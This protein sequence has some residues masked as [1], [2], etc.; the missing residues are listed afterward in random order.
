MS[1]SPSVPSPSGVHVSA[2]AWKRWLGRGLRVLLYAVLALWSVLLLAWLTLHW[3]ILPRIGDWRP[4]IEQAASRALGL[5]VRIGALQVVS[6]SWVPVLELRE[7]ELQDERGQRALRLPRVVAAVSPGSLL[8]WQLRLSQ[9]HLDGPEAVVRRDAQGRWHVAGQGLDDAPSLQGEAAADWLFEQPEVVIQRG[10]LLL[11]DEQRGTPPLALEQLSAVLRNGLREHQWRIDAL[12]PAHWGEQISLRGRFQQP[13]LARAGDWKR[14]SGTL[15]A[16]GPRIEG[17][18]VLA[19]LRVPLALQGGSGHWR[20][21]LEARQGQWQHTTLDVALGATSFPLQSARA[22][23][24]LARLETRLQLDRRDDGWR[25]AV[26]GLRFDTADG[27]HWPRSRLAVHWRPQVGQPEL[28]SLDLDTPGAGEIEG[29]RLDLGALATLAE[30]LPLA[31]AWRQ[32]LAELEPRGQVLGLQARWS[33]PLQQP[34]HYRVK[35]RLQDLAIASRASPEAGGVGRPGWRGVGLELDADERGGQAQ[36]SLRQ[37]ALLLPGVFEDPVLA[38]DEFDARLVWS[39]QPRRQGGPPQI[40]LRVQDGRFANA[41]ARGDLQ[42]RWRTGDGAAGAPGRGQRYPGTLELSGQ[43]MQARA[44]AVARY[45]PLGVAASARRYVE[46]AVREGVVPRASFRVRGD[47]WDFPFA[48][49]S[50]GD[51]HVAAQVERAVLDYAPAA[52]VGPGPGWPAFTDVAGELVFDRGSMAIR[53]AKARLWGVALHDVNGR[54][55]DLIEHPRLRI[56]G[57]GRGPLTDALRFVDASPVAG[58]TRGALGQAVGSGAADLKL[59]L[60]IPLDDASRATVQGSVV[61][62]GNDVRLRRDLPLLRQARARIEFSDSGFSVSGGQAQ[63]LGGEARF[64]ASSQPDGRVQVKVQG[65]ASAEGLRQASELGALARLGQLA[66]GST[67]YQLQLGF[68]GERTEALFTSPLSGLA[69]ELPA[70]LRKSA[71][72]S[73]PLRVQLS[74]L[75][76]RG[77]PPRETLRVDLGPVL[78]AEYQREGVGDSPRVLRGSL[79]IGEAAPALPAAGVLASLKLG[80]V[81]LDEWWAWARG[82]GSDAGVGGSAAALLPTE[83]RA[84]AQ[85]LHNAALPLSQVQLSGSR[86]PADGLWQARLQ[87]DQAQGQLEWRAGTAALPGGQI[88][89]RLT[90]LSVPDSPVAEARPGPTPEPARSA[91]GLPALDVVV[92]ELDWKGKRLGR[93][94][95][96]S[97]ATAADARE[98]PINRLLIQRP[99]ARLQAQGRWSA[100]PQPGTR[101]DL[102]LQ[103][104]DSGALLE[105]WGLGRVLKGGK[106]EISG[107]LGWPGGPMEPPGALLSGELKL[108]LGEGQILKVEPGAGRLLGILSLQSLPRR[109][110]L[111]FRDIFQEGFSF[112]DISG[113]I[114]LADGVARTSNLR[115]RGLQAAVLVEGSADMRRETQDLHML[116]VPELNAGAASLAYAAVNPAIALGTFIAQ[117]LLREPLQQAGTRE[118]RVRGSWDQPQV[119]AIERAA[120]AASAPGQTAQR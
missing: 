24:A 32:T 84:S 112:D 63:A 45:L 105:Q 27:L 74:P 54:I 71:A 47:L 7:V 77:G 2:P 68:V 21:W 91:G 25:L 29:D 115:L 60:D 34:E 92:N 30:H 119:E 103:L 56:E 58:W 116:V 35:A 41:D 51:F 65:Q 40:E 15:Y 109:L 64:E 11:I 108:A 61:L 76:N 114:R 88:V 117:Y 20:V 18:V 99:E 96:D 26:D 42:L 57:A 102:T 9:L 33:G 82:Q 107:R 75:D 86:R 6:N 3:G 59:A 13:L 79:G 90:R 17:A 43:L 111:D 50:D 62:G 83:L 19:D 120:A 12:P 87:S 16:Q 39:V 31:P 98:W 23:L 97:P 38:L 44:A 80:R 110:T 14:W 5:P 73:W 46:A 113:D 100:Q 36:L 52:L 55:D 28:S 78:H 4:Q 101:L 53:R 72:E 8:T 10:R 1:A 67:P 70:P 22:P 118:F 106:G 95:L 85:A 69:I 89:A 48:G 37:G 93:L 66:S 104:A 49:R 94:E 81:D